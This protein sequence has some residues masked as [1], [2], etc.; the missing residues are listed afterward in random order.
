MHPPDRV[1]LEKGGQKRAVYDLVL[2]L[3]KL[4]V[5]P[6]N[7]CRILKGTV[8]A[9]SASGGKEWRGQGGLD[10]QGMK[11]GVWNLSPEGKD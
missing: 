10:L 1:G 7:R 9:G 8:K 11:P 4:P 6:R 2:S 5:L 3:W